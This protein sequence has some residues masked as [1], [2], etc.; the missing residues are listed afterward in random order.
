MIT[1]PVSP[2]LFQSGISEMS[3]FNPLLTAVT[4]AI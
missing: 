2:D 1:V 3:L 4:G